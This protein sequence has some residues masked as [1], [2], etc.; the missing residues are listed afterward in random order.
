MYVVFAYYH[1]LKPPQVLQDPQ[2]LV[3][4]H[5]KFFQD[6][7]AKGRIYIN[8]HGIN[9]QMS[10]HEKDAESYMAWLHKIDPFKDVEF[11]VHLAE[12]H[13]FAKM[14]VKYRKQLAALDAE[15][16]LN[17]TGQHVSPE[18][19]K[20]MLEAKGE[21][22]I[23]IDVRNRYEWEVGHFEGALLPELETFRGFGEY[24]ERLKKSYD[25]E[26]TKVMMYC[27]GGIRCELYSALMKEKGFPEVYQLQGGVIKY[28]L[29]EGVDHWRGKLFVFDDRMVVPISEENTEV[30]S[31]CKFCGTLSDVY[32]NCANMDCNALFISCPA[33]L[34]EQKGCCSEACTHAPRV[35]AFEAEKR[36]KPFRKLPFEIKSSLNA[37]CSL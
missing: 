19:W 23:L 10:I 27:T 4:E 5:Q 34:V 29:E 20:K 15:V 11:K 1:F 22:T 7:D 3:K 16:D 33:C 25:A 30:I 12:E 21:D 28:G 37:A 9:G 13:A 14:T 36:P 31:H 32:V 17:L 2:R 8:E 6:K 18:E 26:K 35:R 24:I